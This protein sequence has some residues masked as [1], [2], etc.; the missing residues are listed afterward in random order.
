MTF[1]A[2]EETLLFASIMPFL[3]WGKAKPHFFT[4]LA[5]NWRIGAKS[6]SSMKLCV[7]LPSS[8]PCYQNGQELAEDVI[9]ANRIE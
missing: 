5:I 9:L 3:S 8:F 7:D 1:P 2:V 6:L 4:S